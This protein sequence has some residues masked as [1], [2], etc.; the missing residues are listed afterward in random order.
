MMVMDQLGRVAK[1]V[2][3]YKDPHGNNY[4]VKST[5]LVDNGTLT[6]AGTMGLLRWLDDAKW[7]LDICLTENRVIQFV[8]GKKLR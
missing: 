7:L 5:L 6:D 4:A 3:W 1:K 2:G 8:Y